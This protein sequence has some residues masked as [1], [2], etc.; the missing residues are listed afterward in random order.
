MLFQC[1]TSVSLIIA[2][3][4]GIAPFAPQAR[5]VR[6]TEQTMK[7]PFVAL[8]QFLGGSSLFLYGWYLFFTTLIVSSPYRAYRSYRLSS[9]G[10]G[11]WFGILILPLLIGIFLVFANKLKTVGYYLIVFCVMGIAVGLVMKGMHFSFRPIT[12]WNLLLMLVMIGG[13]GGMALGA[14]TEADDGDDA[15]KRLKRQKKD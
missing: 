14:L 12:L 6:S 9:G 11:D 13:G 15:K 2:V 5:M 1:V 8:F 10:R 7:N 3:D 4:C